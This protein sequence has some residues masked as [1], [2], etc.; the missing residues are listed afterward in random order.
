MTL[1][2]EQASSRSSGRI[3]RLLS[4]LRTFFIGLLL[5]L[6]PPT[7]II[8][9]GW[10]QGDMRRTAY[11]RAGP[12]LAPD[13]RLGWLLGVRGSGRISRLLGGLAQNIRSGL[14]LAVC[15]LL[16]TFPFTS[17][18]LAA[19]WA[20]WENSFN[21]G[22]E[23]AFV[24]PLLGLGGVAIFVMIMIYLPMAIAH[25]AVERR[26]FAFFEFRHVRSAVAYSGWRYVFLG[27]TTLF[28]ALPIF[29]SRGLPTFGEGIFPGLADMDTGQVAQLRQFIDLSTAGYLF[30]SLVILRRWSAR[31]YT[32][33]VIWAAKGVDADIWRISALANSLTLTSSKSGR[34]WRFF[35]LVRFLILAAIW[36]GFAF[37]I[38]VGQFLH[39]SWHVWLTHPFTFLP[40]TM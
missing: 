8:V 16:A 30:V 20:G 1:A 23:Q 2:T 12:P 22:Y 36:T 14:N 31:I 24:G 13:D 25:Q 40:W 17:F 26:P 3:S 11:R 6:T 21:K 28:F 32:D 9:L 18:W 38:Y 5:C 37:L 29:A 10:L 39:H 35:R 33:A 19:W 15:L 7:S 34:P 27:A 4:V